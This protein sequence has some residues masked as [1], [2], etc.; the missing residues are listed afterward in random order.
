[1]EIRKK[2]MRTKRKMKKRRRSSL[3]QKDLGKTTMAT[4]KKGVRK[5]TNLKRKIR[6]K[7]D[8]EN[9]SNKNTR[10][11]P[12][13]RNQS[14]KFR[15]SRNKLQLSNN[16]KKR[17][18]IILWNQGTSCLFKKTMILLL[19]HLFPLL[20]TRKNLQTLLLHPTRKFRELN[21]ST[22]AT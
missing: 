1:M 17:K 16:K 12:F 10:P 19:A 11:N 21:R 6:M 20:T 8:S 9:F 13:Q 3:Q 4:A 14:R 22:D 7:R 18:S 5:R 2:R 15:S